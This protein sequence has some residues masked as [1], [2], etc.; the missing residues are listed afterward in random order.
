[1]PDLLADEM[2]SDLEADLEEAQTEGVAAAEILGES[3]PRRFA[4]TWASERGLV[5]ERPPKKSRKRLWIGL[6][7]AFV[8][9][10]VFFLVGAAL[11]TFSTGSANPVRVTPPRRIDAVTVPNVV[12]LRACNAVRVATHA[13]LNVR[14][15][16][17][18]HGYGCDLVVGAQSPA[19][20]GVV[21]RNAM[22]TLRLVRLKS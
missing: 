17:H 18:E 22:L 11:A 10:T 19:A 3:D 20:Q 2:A 6:A 9:L 5:A 14:L 1:V 13:G 7:V 8:L 21:R 4:A 12:G 15:P 16:G